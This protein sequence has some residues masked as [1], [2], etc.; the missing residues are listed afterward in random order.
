MGLFAFYGDGATVTEDPREE[1]ALQAVRL[2]ATGSLDDVTLVELPDPQPGP[3]EVV[4]ALKTAALNRRDW[5]TIIRPTPFALPCTLGSDGA[6]IVQAVGEGVTGSKPG[7][8]VVIYPNLD[9]ARG[10]DVPGSGWEILGVPTD[11]TL[12]TAIRVPAEIVR[13]KPSNLTWD[14]AAALNLAGLTAYRAVGQAR[15]AAGDSLA[16]PAA[17]SGVSTFLVQIAAAL[18]VRVYVTSSQQWKLDR[19]RE[20][21]AAGGVLYT[22]ADW[23][24]QLLAL[25]GGP[26]DAVIDS[27]GPAVWQHALGIL[28]RGG[29]LVNFG[30]TSGPDATVNVRSLYFDWRSIVGTTM[31]SPEEFDALLEHVASASWRPVVDSTFA[32]SEWR[33]AFDRLNSPNRFGKV[34]LR[35]EP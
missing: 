14:E 7:D 18:G 29:R 16:I 11:G 8:E 21:G 20:L 10:D 4:V 26:F 27:V 2:L 6:G 1:H 13:P 31:G 9:W 24:E 30:A 22:A 5:W 12:A 34:V 15:L 17:G 28:R 33:A 23:P 3:G 35:C 32:L 19:A 25:N